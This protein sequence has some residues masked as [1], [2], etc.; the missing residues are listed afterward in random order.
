MAADRLQETARH[1]PA[2]STEKAAWS[3]REWL[4]G[5]LAGGA[6]LGFSGTLSGCRAAPPEET[7]PTLRESADDRAVS[8]VIP[9]QYTRDGAGVRLLRSIGGASLSELDPFLLL[10]EF[11]TDRADDYLAGFPEHPHRGF[12]TVTYM[13]HGAMEHRDV[14][15]NQGRLGPGSAQ[16]MTAGRGIIHS[17]MPQQQQGLLWGFQLWV[18]LPARLKLTRPRYQDIGRERVPEF[19]SGDAQVR[20]VAGRLR[21]KTGP[22]EGIVVNPTMLDITLPAAGAFREPMPR[23]HTVFAYVTAGDVKFGRS[24][25]RIEAPALCVLERGTQV[26]AQS[27]SGGRL[28]VLAAAPL[29][30]PIARSGPFVMNTHAELQQAWQDYRSGRLLGG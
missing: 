30:E 10:D 7:R 28:L 26:S 12:E 2:P 11:H 3:R 27:T 9:G 29:G 4:L 17:E 20:L 23:E 16:W 14:L 18:N 25:Q 1:L 24:S 6:A 22:V 15:G 8:R 13:I 5:S 19:A 21:G